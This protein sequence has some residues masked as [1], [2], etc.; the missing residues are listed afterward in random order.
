MKLKPGKGTEKK[1]RDKF[2]LSIKTSYI[3]QEYLWAWK[4]MTSIW[5]T[6]ENFTVD[7]LSSIWGNKNKMHNHLWSIWENISKQL[8]R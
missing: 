4:H 7:L 5:R 1:D 2:Q 8:N 3:D 6:L